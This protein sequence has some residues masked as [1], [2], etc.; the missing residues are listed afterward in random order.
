MNRCTLNSG[1]T[2]APID[3]VR[4]LREKLRCPLQCPTIYDIATWLREKYKIH[5]QID[6]D[7]SQLWGYSLHTCRDNDDSLINTD[8][9]FIN[10]E[11]ALLV[12]ICDAI[13]YI[14]HD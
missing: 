3:V 9:M 14:S 5:I 2:Y 4:E 7:S 13:N 10:F 12:G 6:Y 8:S 11:S 1:D